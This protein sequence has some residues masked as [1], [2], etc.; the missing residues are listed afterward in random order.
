MADILTGEGVTKTECPECGSK[1]LEIL[2]RPAD[3]WARLCRACSALWG[4]TPRMS[5]HHTSAEV[6]ALL[7][8]KNA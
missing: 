8:Y 3:E 5:F 7:D 6:K 1:D 2:E 4:E